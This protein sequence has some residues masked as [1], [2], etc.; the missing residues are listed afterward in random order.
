VLLVGREA[1][2]VR[3]TLRLLPEGAGAGILRVCRLPTILL[4]LLVVIRV[5]G[6]LLRLRLLLR[7]PLRMV[8][9]PVRVAGRSRP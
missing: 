3:G 6:G 1:V 5:R 7:L 2:W 9:G 4:L 8:M